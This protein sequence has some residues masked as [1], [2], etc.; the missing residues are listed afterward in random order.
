MN[1]LVVG[2]QWGDEGK[3]KVVDVLTETADV[4]VR[5]QGGDNAGHTVEVDGQ[6]FVLHLIPSGILWPGKCC[7]IG[8]GLVLDPVALVSE[9]RSIQSR[10]IETEGRILVSEGAHL[11]LPHHRVLDVHSEKAKGPGKIGTTGRGIGPAY[12]DKVSRRG[13]RAVDLLRA[14]EFQRKLGQRI[15]EANRLLHRLG[16][17]PLD[18]G[19]ITEEY[20]AAAQFLRPVITNTVLWLH[21]ALA[22][23]KSLLFESAQGTF[24]DVDFGT[25]PYVTACNTTAGAALVGSGVSPKEIHHVVGCVKAYTTRVGEGPMP[26]ESSELTALL[27]AMGREFGSTTRRARRCGW[28]DSVLVR[29]ARLINGFDRLAVTNLDNLDCLDEIPVCV[30]Y[31][32]EGRRLEYPPTALEDWWNCQPV[33]RVFP[34]WKEPTGQARSFRQLPKPAR[35]YLLGLAELVGAPLGLVSVGAGRE[36]SFW[37]E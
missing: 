1:T 35:D 37:V 36:K 30:A 23:G 11:V 4:V 14:D 15:E 29:Y 8:N 22:K 20:L 34:G 32:L 26:T 31:N 2:A 25:Y 33:Y 13:L 5:C 24:L 28:F 21:D 9:I 3:G 7:V 27:H 12:E 10:G 18:A 6:T 19:G 17:E 16:L